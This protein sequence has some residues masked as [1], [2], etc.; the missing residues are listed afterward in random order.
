MGINNTLPRV[1]DGGMEGFGRVSN[2]GGYTYGQQSVNAAH[3]ARVAEAARFMA[4]V[5]G[6]Q[7]PVYIYE[8]VTKGF[9]HPM[10]RR[11]V[12]STYPL[13][14][15]ESHSVSDFPLLMG[16][17][18]DRMMLAAFRERSGA[19]RQ[20]IREGRALRDFR[21]V[22]RIKID[23]GDGQYDKMTEN[24]GLKY[25]SFD[26]TGYVYAPDLYG[27]GFKFSFRNSV[28]D[29]LGAFEE[30]PNILGRG[31]RRTLAKFAA[32]L[33]FDT[34]G[35]SATLVSNGNGNRI[36]GDPA[37][38]IAALGTGL[39]QLAGF[40]DSEGEPITVEGVRL[41]H[42]PGIMVD[43]NNVLN[44]LTVDVTGSGGTST[45]AVRVNNWIVSGLTTVMEP[46]APLIATNAPNAWALV[47]DP[48][49][50]RPAAEVSGLAGFVEPQLF[51]KMS[52]T[53][54]L[55]GAPQNGLGDFYSMATEYKGLIGF[56]GTTMEPKSLVGSNGTG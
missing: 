11:I 29:D 17:V 38:S 47:A 12:E 18:M 1:A 27:K 56:G 49:V 8:E 32:G 46:Y 28:N 30:I 34:N 31:G 37:F 52:N 22:R 15:H 40:T 54:N 2:R 6:G 43:V 44:Q 20:Y 5:L 21:N 25:T 16:D 55:S 42:G 41:V 4:D 26:E 53:T 23:G 35:V 24:G 19:W 36:S 50:N 9:T 45:Q 48:N 10:Q 7:T 14:I 39:A 13:L 3:T 33:L 51:M